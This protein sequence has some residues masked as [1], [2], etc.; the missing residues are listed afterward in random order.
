MECIV[1][2]DDLYETV[3]I[4]KPDLVG[5]IPGEI[6]ALVNGRHVLAAIHVLVAVDSSSDRPNLGRKVKDILS[7]RLPVLGFL[8]AGRVS[9]SELGVLAVND[10]VC[11]CIEP[12]RRESELSHLSAATAM[13]NWV[14]GCRSLAAEGHNFSVHAQRQ[15][16]NS[17]RKASIRSSKELEI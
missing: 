1:E 8:H 9:G 11:R 14:I 17:A 4:S 16:A 12:K 10:R 6:L 13:T 2:T 7:S 15:L 5:K 3:A